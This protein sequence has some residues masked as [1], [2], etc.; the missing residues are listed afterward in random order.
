M[1]TEDLDLGDNDLNGTIPTFIRNLTSLRKF[2][3]ASSFLY[4]LSMDCVVM[5][6][7]LTP[8]SFAFCSQLLHFSAITFSNGLQDGLT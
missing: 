6:P 4:L 1:I 3:Y 7:N 2:S 5:F 8:S